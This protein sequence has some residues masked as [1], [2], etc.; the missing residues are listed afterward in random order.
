V[1]AIIVSWEESGFIGINISKDDEDEI[2]S[3]LVS[4]N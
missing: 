2:G 1:S 3:S 4:P